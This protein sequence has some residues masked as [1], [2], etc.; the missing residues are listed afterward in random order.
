MPS[1]PAASGP[2]DHQIDSVILQHLGLFRKPGVVSVRPGLRITG[3]KLT[4]SPAIVVSVRK[5][6]SNIPPEEM[7]PRQL[8]GIPVDVRPVSPTEALRA[9]DPEAFAQ[10]LADVPRGNVPI[11][12]QTA[13]FP[14]ERNLDGKLISPLV[15]AAV[16][17]VRPRRPGEPIPGA[18]AAHA[19]QKLQPELLKAVTDTFKVTCFASPAAGWQT[20][21]PFIGSVKKT[22]TVGMFE[23]TAP[24]IVAAVQ[25][26]MTGKTLNLVLDDPDYDTTHREQTNDVTHQ[27]LAGTLGDGMKFAWAAEGRDE[28]NKIHLFPAAY[29]IKVAVAD[30]ESFFLSSG[31]FNTSNQ[32]DFDPINAPKSTDAN[33]SSISDRDWHVIVEHGGLSTTFENI[34]LRD[35]D[36]ALPGQQEASAPIL[37]DSV[38][39]VGRPYKEFPAAR[40]F[41]G[42]MTIQPALTP[43]NYGAVILP[44][45]QQAKKRFWMQTQYI[46]PSSRFESDETLPLAQRTILG[47]LIN[48]VSGLIKRR[49]DVR[50]IVDARVTASMI[51]YLDKYG[52][53]DGTRVLRQVNVHNKGMVIDDDTVV[54]GSQ[55][56]ST[57]G[58]DTNRDASLVIRHADVTA[59]WA[60]IFESDW[61][62]MTIPDE[63]PQSS[64]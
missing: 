57:E 29:H 39:R 24:H 58:V 52:G 23:F 6:T 25:N 11:E 50:I 14:L 63:A 18:A 47:Q 21:G 1:T 36:Q 26:S 61:S 43:D 37:N 2:D 31:N 59:Y 40:T 28:H 38:K 55:N 20:L 33:T 27:Q 4:K 7:L 35:L 62:T 32:P 13:N 53:I 60:G 5:K 17:R 45:I 22:L 30:K 9:T 51:E 46:K 16:A 44:L 3:G 10:E 12:L 42:N 64:R 41:S 54:V 15:D 8:E 34:I 19:Y 49:V 56:W 48:A